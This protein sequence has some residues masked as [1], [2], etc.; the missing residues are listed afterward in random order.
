MRRSPSLRFLSLLFLALPF[1]AL[2]T[3]PSCAKE[4]EPGSCY[5]DPDN[6]CVSYGAPMAGAGKRLCSSFRWIRQGRSSMPAKPC[7]P[8]LFR[9]NPHDHS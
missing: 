5:R 7:A 3:L 4:G 8:I 1:L 2:L 6:A 9:A